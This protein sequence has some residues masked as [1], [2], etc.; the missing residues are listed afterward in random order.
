[1]FFTPCRHEIS[2]KPP[3][4]GLCVVHTLLDTYT[5]IVYYCYYPN[6]HTMNT[7][8]SSYEFKQAIVRAVNAYKQAYAEEYKILLDAIAMKKAMTRDQYAQLEGSKDSRALY[9]ISETLQKE[10]VKELSKNE[11][12]LEWFKTKEGAF[13]FVAAFPQFALPNVI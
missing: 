12:G 11:G 8:S 10:L 6:I 7:L 13:W 1:M 9:E 5:H 3:K 4:G 2:Q